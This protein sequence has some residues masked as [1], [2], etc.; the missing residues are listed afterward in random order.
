MAA[1]TIANHLSILLCIADAAESNRDALNLLRTRR[2]LYHYRHSILLRHTSIRIGGQNGIRPL[3][4]LYNSAGTRLDSLSEKILELKLAILCCLKPEPAHGRDRCEDHQTLA[5]MDVLVDEAQKL[6]QKSTKVQCLTLRQGKCEHYKSGYSLY[7]TAEHATLFTG[8]GRTARNLQSL[9]RLFLDCPITPELMHHLNNLS[10]SITHLIISTDSARYFDLLRNFRGIAPTLQQL[11]IAAPFSGVRMR[12]HD[13]VEFPLMRSLSIYA[14]LDDFSMVNTRLLARTY[15]NLRQ[16]HLERSE[17]PDSVA[18]VRETS[19][20]TQTDPTQWK[21]LDYLS[22]E[23]YYIHVLGLESTVKTL[24][25]P[26]LDSRL[27]I[28]LP[29]CNA[30]RPSSLHITTPVQP[31]SIQPQEPIKIWTASDATI[32]QI[33]QA[34]D[35]R[36]AR[37]DI[38]TNNPETIKRENMHSLLEEICKTSVTALYLHHEV[39]E[40]YKRFQNGNVSRTFLHHQRKQRFEHARSL[41]HALKN[42]SK[43]E[44]FYYELKIIGSARHSSRLVEILEVPFRY[45]RHMPSKREKSKYTEGDWENSWRTT[46][47][48]QDCTCERHDAIEWD[49]SHLR[50]Y[51]PLASD[52]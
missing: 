46:L 21:H 25:M 2:A 16:M 14:K 19:T 30:L 4:S 1:S 20:E 13:A 45:Y 26:I 36:K 33:L 18:D 32:I 22:S 42:G 27:P 38:R 17:R 28:I 49:S 43:I 40:L 5:S 24:C 52:S 10:S 37:I 51:E 23:A 41:S 6:L 12:S 50:W 9:R 3:Q 48:M 44:H 15:P 8:L 47:D 34:S 29:I 11:T 39:R 35:A 7:S 31:R